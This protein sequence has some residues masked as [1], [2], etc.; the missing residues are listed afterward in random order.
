M[1]C[2]QRDKSVF[3]LGVV[4]VV[5]VLKLNVAKLRRE[6]RKKTRTKLHR[7]RTDGS[8]MYSDEKVNTSGYRVEFIGAA[9]CVSSHSLLNV[10]VPGE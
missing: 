6:Q 1:T 7:E 2:Q 9:Q 8:Y 10:R 5:S 3:L 4:A